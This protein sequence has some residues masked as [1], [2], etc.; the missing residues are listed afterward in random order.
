MP[1]PH[2]PKAAPFVA[3]PPQPKI[4]HPESNAAIP[5]ATT[6]WPRR[7][8]LRAVHFACPDC[9]SVRA[10]LR[11]C[12]HLSACITSHTFS[13]IKHLTIIQDSTAIGRE[14]QR[15]TRPT[16]RH[17][18]RW[19]RLGVAPEWLESLEFFRRCISKLCP[20]EQSFERIGERMN[21]NTTP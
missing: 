21:M 10:C 5:S 7:R 15:F 20:R 14:N 11:A 18:N 16:I 8:Q 4:P 3:L 1:A 17:S 2:P 12:R 13:S 19:R 9:L 6:P